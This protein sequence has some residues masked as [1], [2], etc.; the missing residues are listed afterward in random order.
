[1]A[2]DLKAPRLPAGW[3]CLPPSAGPGLSRGRFH[4]P[5]R[6]GVPGSVNGEGG[7]DGKQLRG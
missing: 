4:P 5:T 7:G 1:M 2:D 3:G 6:K